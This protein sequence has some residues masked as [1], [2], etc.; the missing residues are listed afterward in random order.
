MKV[1]SEIFCLNISPTTINI[2]LISELIKTRQKA[3]LFKRKGRSIKFL[4]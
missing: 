3:G 2:E 4:W 1:T